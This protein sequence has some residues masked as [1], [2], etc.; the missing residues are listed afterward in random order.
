MNPIR[1]VSS[2]SVLSEITK[3][4]S[5]GDKILDALAVG[6]DEVLQDESYKKEEEE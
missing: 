5:M 2:S 6:E 1:K 3:E 4:I